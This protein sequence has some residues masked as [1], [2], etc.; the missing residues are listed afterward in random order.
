M[1]LCSSAAKWTI[2]KE[3]HE[4]SRNL[5]TLLVLDR[6]SSSSLSIQIP[7]RYA[8]RIWIPGTPSKLPNRAVPGGTCPGWKDRKILESNSNT[9]T[10]YGHLFFH[11]KKRLRN[12]VSSLPEECEQTEIR[13]MSFRCPVKRWEDVSRCE[14]EKMWEDVEGKRAREQE[15]KREKMWRWEDVRRWEDVKMWEDVRRCEKMWADVK[16]R[17]CERM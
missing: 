8:Q 5:G 16:M 15:G 3:T 11:G 9:Q 13:K 14:D 12:A 4:Q 10:T 7:S 2:S 17:R 6:N 1:I